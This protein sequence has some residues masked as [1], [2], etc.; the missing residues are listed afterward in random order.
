MSTGTI[1]D[2]VSQRV[3]FG[4]TRLLLLVAKSG[5][6]MPDVSEAT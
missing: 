6:P 2:P 1:G 3:R 5:V 4:Y